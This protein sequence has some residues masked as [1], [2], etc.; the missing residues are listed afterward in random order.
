MIKKKAFSNVL[1]GQLLC[2]RRD[3]RVDVLLKAAKRGVL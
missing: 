3:E 1:A 2:S